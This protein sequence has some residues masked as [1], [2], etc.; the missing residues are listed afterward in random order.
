[1]PA[2]PV[3]LSKLCQVMPLTLRCAAAIM[4]V[5][6][7]VVNTAPLHAQI[8]STVYNFNSAADGIQP[9]S[10]MVQAADGTLYGTTMQGGVYN[11]GSIFKITPDARFQTI[12]S[13]DGQNGDTPSGPLAIGPDGAV[14]GTTNGGGGYNKL[15]YNEGVVFKITP[16]GVE[17]VI[18]TFHYPNLNDSQGP[19]MGLV[20]D[21]ADGNFYGTI[22]KGGASNNG[23]IFQ[24]TPAGAY[25]V[26][27][28]L[29]SGTGQNPRGSLFYNP[30][31]GL[32]YGTT[33]EG[34]T[35]G[36]GTIFKVSTT[37]ALTV[38]KNLD[39]ATGFN[40][41]TS[42]QIMQ[43]ADGNLYG[44]LNAGGTANQGTIFKISGGVFSTIYNF[45]GPDGGTPESRLVQAA[46]GAL[47]GTA[48]NGGASSHGIVFRLTPG[49][50]PAVKTIH[51]FTGTGDGSQPGDLTL[52]ANGL[53]YGS[54]ST[55]GEKGFGSVFNTT[56]TGSFFIVKDLNKG[57]H[58]GI[59]PN[60]RLLLAKDG[61]YYGTTVNI[62]PPTLA[63][64][65]TIYQ[66]TPQGIVHAL[67]TFT[68]G[69]PIGLRPMGNLV[70][71][72]DGTFYGVTN[73]NNA[74]VYKFT[75]P[76]HSAVTTPTLLHQ[77]DGSQNELPA[78]GLLLASDGN[79]YGTTIRGGA[80]NL[81][82]LFRLTPEGVYTVLLNFTGA[83]GYNGSPTLF[84]L[85]ALVQGEDGDLYGVMSQGGK[86]NAGSIFR[87][88]TAGSLIWDTSL[89]SDTAGTKSGLT[90][91]ADGNLYGVSNSGG[92]NG[93]GS[94]FSV[95]TAGALSL[96]YSFDTTH[97]YSPLGALALAADGS[98]YGLTTSGGQSKHGG[99]FQYTADGVIFPADFATSSGW[100]IS[101]YGGDY[102]TPTPDGDI[103]GT[104][105]EGGSSNSG[106]IY[107]YGFVPPTITSFAPASGKAGSIVKI[108]GTNFTKESAVKFNGVL[109]TALT[110][111]SPT[112][113]NATVP[114]NATSG[115]IR[116][117]TPGGSAA[118]STVFTVLPSVTS[119]VPTSGPVG[120]IV[121]ITGAGFTGVTAVTFHGIGAAF[122][123]KST[124]TI[125]A[126]VPAGAT[127]GGILVTTPGGVANS[128][129]YFNVVPPMPAITTFSPASGKIG[130]LVTIAGTNFNGTTAVKFNGVAASFTVVS[131]TKITVTVPEHASTGPIS[132]KTDNGTTAS[133]SAFTVTAG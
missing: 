72:A 26:I 11:R 123:V 71:S 28:S 31:D 112:Q 77:F 93:K 33:T 64:N 1:M 125:T 96:K 85:G 89:T 100:Y 75:V 61:N 17:S 9:R 27:T 42:G 131:P 106:S 69:S 46:D 91:G 103:Y 4:P 84:G 101:S 16:D 122:T 36:Q 40:N 5:L 3:R 57:I 99:L 110:M 62:T 25:T 90:F 37:G 14:Y 80:N 115:L 129:A 53:L 51:S 44:T 22:A 6:C 39:S 50:T 49:A 87:I 48:T 54:A 120:T 119:I 78:G 43:A 63:L 109:A 10:G 32:L 13:F 60:N 55:G 102:L 12:Y 41:T 94:I 104:S 23:L 98:L 15:Q 73:S 34:G 86:N 29:D 68:S 47:Y 67:Y 128:S 130:T 121:T 127:T 20:Y 65:G 52:A 21:S 97:G 7:G 114:L 88:T 35:A 79:L 111:V 24:V 118:G 133:A 105:F 18:Y 107:R 2:E 30:A 56:T 58:D 116:A 70:Q 124:T 82:T 92:A 108:K 19:P 83:T 95:T 117:V 81:G 74:V 132:V 45:Q 38:I 126:T 8:I 66:M 76:G 59:G 113:I